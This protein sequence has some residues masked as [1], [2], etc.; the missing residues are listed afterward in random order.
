M[1]K[2]GEL[3]KPISNKLIKVTTNSKQIKIKN[4]GVIFCI[5]MLFSFSARN[6]QITFWIGE[7]LAKSGYPEGHMRQC[8]VI[9]YCEHSIFLRIYGRH[10]LHS[11]PLAPHF[12]S[13]HHPPLIA[14]ITSPSV[15]RPL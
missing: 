2:G 13:T 15:V 8:C 1:G 5:I 14:A 4:V 11:V 6:D 10:A 12:I 7:I 9:C 3:L